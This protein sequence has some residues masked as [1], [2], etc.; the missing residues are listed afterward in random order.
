MFRMCV[1]MNIS[2][3]KICFERVQA[4]PPIRSIVGG[5]VFF[6][7]AGFQLKVTT[8]TTGSRSGGRRNLLGGD[9]FSV[10]R[11][12]LC[13][14]ALD[15]VHLLDNCP[16]VLHELGPGEMWPHILQASSDEVVLEERIRRAGRATALLCR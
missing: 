7:Y 13:D 10:F 8:F 9:C 11:C 2:D 1:G 16:I 15:L 3:Y 5:L 14:G 6:L 4:R 12:P